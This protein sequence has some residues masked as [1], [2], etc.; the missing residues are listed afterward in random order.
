MM[1][2][3]YRI[4]LLNSQITKY[5]IYVIRTTGRMS[6]EEEPVDP[7]EIV[8]HVTGKGPVTAGNEAKIYLESKFIPQVRTFEFR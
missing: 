5:N 8:N 6:P 4:F 7:K 1:S 3:I 2:Y